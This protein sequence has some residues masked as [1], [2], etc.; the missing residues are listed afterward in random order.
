MGKVAEL[1]TVADHRPRTTAG[2]AGIEA[3]SA[4]GGSRRPSPVAPP[5]QAPQGFTVYDLM[6]LGMIVIW[7]ANPSAIKW[8][9]DYMEP[10]VFNALRFTLATLLPVGLL[11]A[12]KESLTWHP[13]DGLKI[14][15]LGLLGNGLYQALFIVAI[16]YTLAGNVALILSVN[17]VFVAIFGALLGYERVRGY[18]WI[19]VGLSL[20]GVVLVI[21]GAGGPLEFGP[22][23]LG[24]VLMVAVTMMWAL[25]TVLSQ[26]LLGRYSAVKLNALTMPT[27]AILLL[28]LAAP[29][30][31][32]TAPSLPSVPA[33]AWL[34]L[35]GSGL[36]AISASYIVWYKGI[37]KLGATRASIYTNLV[38]VLA[39]FFSYFLLK[40][41]LGWQFWT[42]MLL[43]L[44]GVS[45]ARFGGRILRR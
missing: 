44:A 39:A 2:P 4:T 3:S 9:L 22:R 15:G 17:P 45:I 1:G 33:A 28:L 5:A 41:P 21:S 14:F 32:R 19:G 27:G 29:A 7:A 26:R 40:E 42:G 25:Y 18:T 12:S 35:V 10:L 20:A 24:D 6:L 8:A 38:P 30:L 37:Q 43:V 11:L 16:D 36:L 34:V 23:L 13:G 31:V